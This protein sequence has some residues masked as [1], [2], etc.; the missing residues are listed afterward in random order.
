MYQSDRAARSA[1]RHQVRRAR[2]MRYDGGFEPHWRAAMPNQSAQPIAFGKYT[3]LERIS[4]GGMAEVFRA[5]TLGEA[6]FERIVAIKLLLP[7]VA[8]DEEFV[9]M[10][11]DE[12]KIA[13]QLSH[14]NIAQIF[15]LGRAEDRYYIVQE[16][17]PGR[18]LRAILRHLSDG[19]Q[20][21]TLAQACH[22]LLKVCE[23]LDYAH[24]KRDAA[25]NPLNLVHRDIS[26]QNVIASYEGEIKL[27]DFGIVKAEG[28]A[29]RT[30]AG[31]VKGKFAYMSPEQLRGLPVDRRS[32]VFACGIVL[33]ELLTGEPLF[34]RGT[35]FE[36][37][38]R[39]RYGDIEPPSKQN[40]EV[41]P[42]L[43]R[44]ALKA[45]AR[46][47][48]DR[49]QNALQFRDELWEFVRSHG[50][51]YTRNEMAA[52]MRQ[53]FPDGSPAGE[54]DSEP[55][56]EIEAVTL[57]PGLQPPPPVQRSTGQP[58]GRVTPPPLDYDQSDPDSE[59]PQDP[60]VYGDMRTLVEPGFSSRFAADQGPGPDSG[61]LPRST[62]PMGSTAPAVRD[63]ADAALSQPDRA[64]FI[65]GNDE[66][67]LAVG[68]D[69]S[70]DL[71]VKLP[72]RGPSDD[73]E[74]TSQRPSASDPTAPA[75][76]QTT[77]PAAGRDGFAPATDPIGNA[78]WVEPQTPTRQR[79]RAIDPG[80]GTIDPES[81]ATSPYLPAMRAT[82]GVPTAGGRPP[83][84]NMQ[85]STSGDAVKD[86]LALAQTLGPSSPRLP[87]MPPPARATGPL[88]SPEP[89]SSWR[90]ELPGPSDGGPGPMPQAR[91]D[92]ST[93]MP[94]PGPPGPMPG[95]SGMPMPGPPMP[96]QE[97][98]M[99][100]PPMSMPSPMPGPPM[101]MQSPMPGP[102][103]SM[104]SPMPGP[105]MSMQSPMTPMPGPMHQGL[106][107]GHPPPPARA[108]ANVVLVGGA[109]LVLI[110]AVIASIVLAASGG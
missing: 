87:G 72:R 55:A 47:V 29:T 109:V 100:G 96:M 56:I 91:P 69:P 103:M 66:G 63:L 80:E 73:E 90:A 107:Y 3:L 102:P 16:Y 8:M 83:A 1:A 105:P 79:P 32:D 81:Q 34:K 49:Y 31:L 99:P 41:P 24:N 22:I 75:A 62:K 58:P 10:L 44:I 12:A 97:M 53:T 54:P 21:L 85:A 64:V 108:R 6:G 43:D 40:R 74:T 67:R 25:G 14:A 23:G 104:P 19:D 98:Q 51:F 84:P 92:R 77:A 39:A 28:R 27:I 106:P 60:D 94:D 20:R 76:E 11:I 35:E 18:D 17:V 110:A 15:D 89:P 4:H 36:T 68:S 93:P 37:L 45:L 7:Q 65:P 71:A 26:P 88:P 48:D 59:L 33:H 13:G 95:P 9:T 101:S 46:H 38:R 2:K 86:A 70:L 50:C 78:R 42:E 82:G 52:W 57:D 30:L 5:R 61:E